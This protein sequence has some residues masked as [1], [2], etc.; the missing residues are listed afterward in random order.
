[1]AFEISFLYDLTG[2]TLTATIEQIS[3]GFYWN[4][5]ANAFQSAPTYANKKI[6][7]T[8]GVKGNV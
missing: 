8:E 4:P 6:A 5:T 1:M 3:D 7:L 2:R